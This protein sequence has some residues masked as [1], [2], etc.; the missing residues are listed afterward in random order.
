MKETNSLS[1]SHFF[2]KMFLLAFVYILLSVYISYS[3]ITF[4]LYSLCVIISREFIEEMHNSS[5]SKGYNC[6]RYYIDPKVIT[7]ICSAL[8]YGEFQSVTIDVSR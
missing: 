8:P 4:V 2:L 5:E 3:G 6:C 1:N 7:F